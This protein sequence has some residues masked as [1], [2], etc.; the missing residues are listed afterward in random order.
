[1]RKILVAEGVTPNLVSKQFDF[2]NQITSETCLAL[3]YESKFDSGIL[4]EI[5]AKGIPIIG[6]PRFDKIDQTVIMDRYGIRHPESFYDIKKYTCIRDIDTLNSY[7]DLEEFVVKPIFGARGIGVK[8]VT[9]KE[10]KECLINEKKVDEVFEEE[11]RYLVSHNQDT[12]QN[13]IKD[14]IACMLIQESINVVKEYRFLYFKHGVVLGY[15]R[16]KTP[17]QFCGNLSHGATSRVMETHEVNKVFNPL[18]EQ[19]NNLTNEY[20]YPWLS[21][22]VY[23]DDK[24]NIGVFEFQ[25]EFAYEGFNHVEVRNCMVNALNFYINSVK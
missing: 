24:E 17:G 3:Q 25:M 11:N 22:D 5:S 2:E 8:K 9:R 13:F 19:F 16:V 10:F 6:T 7:C 20:K 23:I 12:P 21:I 1:M 14:N 15:E 18:I 4:K